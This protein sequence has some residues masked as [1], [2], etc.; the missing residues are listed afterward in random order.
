MGEHG[1]ASVPG[2]AVR[3]GRRLTPDRTF[4]PIRVAVAALLAMLLPSISPGALIAATPAAIVSSSLASVVEGNAGNVSLGFVITLDRA[5]SSNVTVVATTVDGSATAGTDYDALAPITVTFAPGTTSQIVTVTAHGDTLDEGNYEWLY[6]QLSNPVGADFSFGNT[7]P[8]NIEGRIYDDDLTPPGPIILSSSLASVVEGNSGNVSLGFVITLDRASSSNV[9]VVATTQDGSATVTGGDYDALAPTLVT[10]NPGVTSQPVTVTVH[11]D[12]IDEGNSEYLLLQLSNPVGADFGSGNTS[13]QYSEGRIYDD[14][15]TAIPAA[16]VS[17]SL[18]SVVEGNAGTVN[19]GFVVTLDRILSSPVTVVATTQDGSATVTGGD[20]DA[21]APTLVTFNPGV[22]SQP[23]TVTVHGDMIDE[24]NSEYLLL[25]LSNP[26]GADFGSGNTSP[27][28]SE[29]RIYDDDGAGD[30]VPSPEIHA[31]TPSVVEGNA[32]DVLLRFMLSLDRAATSNVSIQVESQDGSAA[33]ADSDYVA[34]PPTTLTFAPGDRVKTVDVTVHGDTRDEGESEYLYLYLSNPSGATIAGSTFTYGTIYDDEITPVPSPEIHATTPSVVEGNAGDVLLRFMLS[35]DRAATSNVSIQ[36]ES[37]DGSAAVA[38]SDYVAV[39][40]TTLTFAPG[41]RVKTVDVTVHGDTRDE[42]ESEYLYLYLSNPS[43]ATIAGSTFTY[44]TIYDDEITLVPS[45]DIHVAAASVVEGDAGDVTLRF[46]LSLDRAPSS[47]V[48][49]VAT[50]QDSS[51]TVADG[52]YVAVPPTTVTFTPADQIKTVD[53]TVHGDIRD[54]GEA[55]YLYLA[56]SNPSGAT[57]PGFPY[58]L[59]TIYDD[60]QPGPG[61]LRFD[62]SS[63]SISEGVGTVAL[64]V[65][66]VGGST[67]AVSVHFST[68]NGTATSGQDYTATSSTLNWADGETT[69]KSVVVAIL[70]D[71]VSEGSETFTVSLDSPGGGAALGI[72]S[73]TTVTIVDDEVDQPPSADAGPAVSGVEGSP[74]QLT[75]TASDV[76][77]QSPTIAWSANVAGLDAGASC[78]FSPSANVASPTVRCTDDGTVTLTISVNDG[79]NPAVTDTTSLTLTNAAPVVT[80]SAPTDGSSHAITSPLALS[81]TISDPGTNDS[82]TCGIDWG[83][84]TTGPATVGLV[85]AGTC[86]ASH[87]YAN[88]GPY[89]IGV[90]VTDDDTA[91]ASAA[92][93]ITITAVAN[94]CHPVTANAFVAV[95]PPAS[96]TKGAQTSD[97][98]II[99]FGEQQ[100]YTLGSAGL[101]VDISAPGCYDRDSPMPG[102]RLPAGTIVNSFLLH[103]DRA[104]P[105]AIIDLEGEATID[106]DIIGVILNDA[107]LDASDAVTGWPYTVYPNRSRQ[108]GCRGRPGRGGRFGSRSTP[109]GARSASHF[110]FSLGRRPGP[111]PD[112][113]GPPRPS[114]SVTSSGPRATPGPR[115]SA[116][117]SA[118]R[119]PSPTTTS[120]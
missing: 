65:N 20:Y 38:D 70:Q 75:G 112:Q 68:A 98:R 101:A 42:G 48:T 17:S 107:P 30:P 58:A 69:A 106:S 88:P 84:G 45:P 73:S 55:E 33:V 18:A 8:Q 56:L 80:I 90:T 29:G 110:Q 22:T 78:S 72:P 115:P 94:V 87:T 85:S 23:V 36:V 117:R 109:T 32:G 93:K 53:V 50:T 59:G 76:E 114:P 1:R 63:Y 9:T 104:T 97:R 39:P 46:T 77:N 119:P 79:V 26:V 118:S 113:A 62:S 102:L 5:S 24:G 25:Q 92:V 44:G 116:S 41:D 35:L 83:D 64:T 57:I 67:G 60:D 61:E 111:H 6:L 71:T 66:R 2:F 81:A 31:T 108:P 34:V 27:Q 82:H 52:D 103:A 13:P 95:S 47:N 86:T 89:T 16:I 99:G 96:V 54:E 51:A 28:Y 49:V 3:T 120:A 19:L 43:G 14:D 21:L 74:V 7:F 100:G 15:R 11:G 105:N 4:R 40:P 91:S 10:F 37:Q 12:M